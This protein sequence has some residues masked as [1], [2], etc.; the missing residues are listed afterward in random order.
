MQ[1][2]S[3]TQRPALWPWTWAPAPIRRHPA[4][5]LAV[6]ARAFGR[7]GKEVEP[8]LAEPDPRLPWAIRRVPCLDGT[9]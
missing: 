6:P 8:G 9:P 4:N 1:Q 5:R 7:P 2:L 3:T